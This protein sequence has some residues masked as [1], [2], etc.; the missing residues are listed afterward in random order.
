[1]RGN[2]IEDKL[3]CA[4]CGDVIGTYE[5]MVALVDGRA[6]DTSK[7]AETGNEECLQ[8]CYH[9]ACYAHA[10]GEATE[11]C[12]CPPVVNSRHPRGVCRDV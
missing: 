8:N 6:R 2:S 9:Q 5:P 3:R 11:T 10:R 7:A 4:H 12:A 1:M